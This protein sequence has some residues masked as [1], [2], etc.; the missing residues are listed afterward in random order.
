MDSHRTACH[1]L[2]AKLPAL[3]APGKVL[4]GFDGFVDH[5]IGVVDKRHGPDAYDRVPTIS[6]LAARIGA[7]A[8]HSANL[9][10]VITRSKIGGNGPIMAD[11]IAAQGG[12]VT[13]A[14]LLGAQGIH[15]VFQ[16]MAARGSTLVSFGDPGVTDALEF[17]DGKLMLG[18]LE[19][20]KDL[21][22]ANIEKAFGG[23]DGLK[24]ALRAPRLVAT[25]NWTMSL[26][27]TGIWRWLAKE[28]LPGLRP[29]RPLWFVDLADPAKRPEAELVD[30]LAALR[31]LQVHADVV[32]GLNGA[33]IR[34]VCA[35][36][37][38]P[39]TGGAGEDNAAAE[40]ACAALRD[41]LG[42]HMVMC[43]LTGSAACAWAAPAKGSARADGFGTPKPKITTGAGDHF[44]AGFTG[45]LLSGLAPAEALLVGGATSGTYVRDAA[46]PDRCRLAA[47]LAAWAEHGPTP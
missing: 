3:P 16:P 27:M 11:A 46:S 36:T 34:Q 20:L 29:D 18:K 8:G 44:N 10:L 28:V 35:A 7:A 39:W 37:G 45:A 14:G 2:A 43:H 42:L 47:F 38:T 9:E 13:C 5:I 21:N 25:V 12:Q 17:D 26:A 19:T 31:E 22:A 32:L 24:A 33:E 15:P 40:T 23:R 4:V 1:A 6:A 30:G 41:R